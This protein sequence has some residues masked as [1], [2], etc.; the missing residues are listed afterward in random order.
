M[1][2]ETTRSERPSH[3][4]GVSIV[5]PVYKRLEYLPTALACVDRQDHPNIELIVSDNGNNGGA[6]RQLVSAH[7]SRTFTFR[8]NAESVP[9][10]EHFNQ[11]FEAASMPYVTLLCDDDEISPEFASELAE[12]L[13]RHPD[14]NVALPRPQ[15]IRGGN[16]E[17]VE[18]D[19]PETTLAGDV[20][21]RAYTLRRVRLASTVTH[22]ARTAQVRQCGGYAP[23][24]KALYSDNLLLTKLALTGDVAFAKR[25]TFRWRVDDA[26]TGFSATHG[27]AAGACRGFM[28]ALTEDALLRAYAHAHPL[29]W[30]GLK[31]ELT[32]HCAQWYLF[33]WSERYSKRL[34]RTR[35]VKAAFA[36]PYIRSYYANVCAILSERFKTGLKFRWPSLDRAYRVIRRRQPDRGTDGP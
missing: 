36:L 35:W 22:M 26:S 23:L 24:P 8:Q 29:V 16:V 11:L 34:S 30:K 2:R 27:E 17:S 6:V 12:L 18:G 9:V 14:A 21:L 19:W 33:R 31:A 3:P 32:S 25:A 5:L 13:D 10:V 1:Q 28:R 4:T 15:V 7:Y 20:F